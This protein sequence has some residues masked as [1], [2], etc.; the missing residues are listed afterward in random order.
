MSVFSSKPLS[1]RSVIALRT[2]VRGVLGSNTALHTSD[3][4]KTDVGLSRKKAKTFLSWSVTEA[5]ALSR[6]VPVSLV[7]L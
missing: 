7:V 2:E 6:A 5:L 1:V 3:G 4:V